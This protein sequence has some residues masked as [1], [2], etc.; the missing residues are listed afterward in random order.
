MANKYLYDWNYGKVRN[1][2]MK[3]HESILPFEQ[4]DED[5]KNYDRQQIMDIREIIELE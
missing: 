4:L 1:T 2:F 5:T 3:E